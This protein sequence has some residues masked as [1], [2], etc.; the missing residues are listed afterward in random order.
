VEPSIV[1][2]RRPF[3]YHGLPIT[4][5]DALLATMS[6]ELGLPVWT[7]TVDHHVDVME[8]AVCW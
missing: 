7:W 8:V 1:A 3:G 5:Y 2:M 4:P 6:D